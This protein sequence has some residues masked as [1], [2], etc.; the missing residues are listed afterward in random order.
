LTGVGGGGDVDGGSKYW[1]AAVVCHL[2][3]MDGGHYV[4][5]VRHH[6]Q[7]FKCDDSWVIPATPQEVAASQAYLLFYAAH[8][9]AAGVVA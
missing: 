5:F 1:C 2:G 9:Q 6:G 8:G 3:S 4:A 7:W